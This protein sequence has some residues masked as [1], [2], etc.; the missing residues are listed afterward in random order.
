MILNVPPITKKPTSLFDNG[1]SHVFGE[2]FDYCYSY[3]SQRDRQEVTFT[4]Q[5]G[6]TVFTIGDPQTTDTIKKYLFISKTPIDLTTK[7]KLTVVF[8]SYEKYIKPE[9]DIRFIY[10]D[11]P[12]YIDVGFYPYNMDDTISEGYDN[13]FQHS[14]YICPYAVRSEYYTGLAHSED[15][16]ILQENIKSGFGEKTISKDIKNLKGEYYFI[17]RLVTYTP[18]NA[19]SSIFVG[20]TAEIKRVTII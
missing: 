17:I 8:P 13:E 9:E 14:T 19:A 1:T 6:V 3:T 16:N 11:I 7:K 5:D 4:V 2:T 18:R 15:D 20:K 12:A 10:Q